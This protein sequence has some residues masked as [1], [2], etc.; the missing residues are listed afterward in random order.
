MGCDLCASSCRRVWLTG[1]WMSGF[2][3]W[4]LEPGVH[5]LHVSRVHRRLV[6][7]VVQRVAGVM[8][9]GARVPWRQPRVRRAL[10]VHV[11]VVR[12]VHTQ[13]PW[14]RERHS[15][16][17]H[18]VPGQFHLNK[19][20]SCFVTSELRRKCYP[21]STSEVPSQSPK[22]GQLG[23]NLKFTR[24]N[25]RACW[26]LSG[27]DVINERNQKRL[28]KSWAPTSLQTPDASHKTVSTTRQGQENWWSSNCRSNQR[29]E[30]KSFKELRKNSQLRCPLF[31]VRRP[32]WPQLT[33]C[34][35]NFHCWSFAV[36]RA[37]ASSS[38][39]QRN[40]QESSTPEHCITWGES[41]SCS[42]LKPKSLPKTFY[43]K[44]PDL[45]YSRTS[46]QFTSWLALSSLR[47]WL[48]LEK[49]LDPQ[50][51]S[52]LGELP[53]SIRNWRVWIHRFF[54]WSKTN[55]TSR[56]SGVHPFQRDIQTVSEHRS[57][58]LRWRASREYTAF[59]RTRSELSVNTQQ[60]CTKFATDA[61]CLFFLSS[62]NSLMPLYTQPTH[63][64]N[65]CNLKM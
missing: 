63:R 25:E 64:A 48:Q 23:K 49:K 2:I 20:F 28:N 60:E 11:L 17:L 1:E 50:G 62:P 21:G 46:S 29:S 43:C 58:N 47:F 56:R 15:C 37:K 65:D 8:L 30:W 26:T 36:A 33:N 39:F 40:A 51:A 35:W 44:V 22:R 59:Q 12:A 3:P 9:G 13:C 45:R 18:S 38:R 5:G 27:R 54:T 41:L 53:S 52:S 10:L 34:S 61:F 42:C 57:E 32:C 7:S 16:V 31:E 19:A 24:A 55:S 4:V 6:S 14:V